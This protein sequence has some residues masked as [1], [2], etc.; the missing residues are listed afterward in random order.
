MQIDAKGLQNY[1]LDYGWVT[2]FSSDNSQSANDYYVLCND[3]LNEIDEET[4]KQIAQLR[5]SGNYDEQAQLQV[6]D[7]SSYHF[8]N[9]EY[10]HIGSYGLQECQEVVFSGKL[11]YILPSFLLFTY[12][13]YTNHINALMFLDLPKLCRILIGERGLRFCHHVIFKGK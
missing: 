13:H 10:L 6:L 3:N 7:F 4:Q 1:I 2:E 9:L 8:D 11:V 12:S 5:F